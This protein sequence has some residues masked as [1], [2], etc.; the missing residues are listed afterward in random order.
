MSLSFDTAPNWSREAEQ[1]IPEYRAHTISSIAAII[2]RLSRMAANSLSENDW[3]N[4]LTGPQIAV[5]RQVYKSNSISAA[6]ISRDIGCTPS[7][8]TGI[9]DRLEKKN[10]LQRGKREHDR[11]LA[12]L[13]L[14]EKGLGIAQRLRDPLQEV[15]QAGL[16]ETDEKRL[17]ELRI[18]LED[19]A[20]VLDNR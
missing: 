20:K 8:L 1:A 16:K 5:L 13:E 19:I 18:A 3:K 9:I 6:Q 7:N 15:L 11:R 4:N 14:T 12:P 10:L 17:E 2:R